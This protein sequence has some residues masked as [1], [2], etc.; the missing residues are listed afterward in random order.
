GAV[1]VQI[2]DGPGGDT[3]G[4]GGLDHREGDFLDQA[5]I[6]GLGNQV[7]TAELELLAGVGRGG[8]LGD[9]PGGQIGDGPHA[10][11]LH[12]GI[13]GGGAAVEGAAEDEREA[14]DVVHLVGVVGASGGEDG[15]GA[16][17]A[18]H[19][20]HDLRHRV[21][22]GEDQ[23]IPGHLLDHVA[24][25]HVG[26]GQAEEQVGV[27]D[28]V[29]DGAIGGV[30]RVLGLPGVHALLAALVDDAVAVEHADV[31]LAQPH[32]AQQVHTGDAGGAGAGNHQLDVLDLLVDDA[33][34]VVDGGGGD[35]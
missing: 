30:H 22:H 10:G 27:G 21:G 25:E 17:G 26:A 32:V 1:G 5:R 18:G 11:L 4:H 16:G 34:A 9:R 20:R 6:E 15:V 35:D 13:D 2:L 28:G 12:L 31:F 14:E 19:L 29:V 23:R 33:Q 8:G 3:A 24:I 7:F